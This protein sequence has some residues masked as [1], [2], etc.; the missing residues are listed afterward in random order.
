MSLNALLNYFTIGQL[1]AQDT[2]RVLSIY[3][4]EI[5]QDLL[6]NK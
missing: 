2:E 4:E 6:M 5:A 3:F 1:S